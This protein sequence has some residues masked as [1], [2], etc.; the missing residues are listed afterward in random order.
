MPWL[1]LQQTG[2]VRPLG[3]RDGWARRW[4]R[5]MVDPLLSAPKALPPLAEVEP[6]AIPDRADLGL[7]PAPCPDRQRGGRDLGLETL[8]GFLTERVR[9]TAPPFG[10]VSGAVR[11]SGISPSLA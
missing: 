8:S 3:N 5:F 6:G 9:P 1:E 4:K 7:T 2:V 10:P 11:C